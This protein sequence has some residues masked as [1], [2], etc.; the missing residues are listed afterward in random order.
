M[1]QTFTII[2]F[3]LL[4]SKAFGMQSLGQKAPS[5][6]SSSIFKLAEEMDHIYT[7]SIHNRIHTRKYLFPQYSI[8]SGESSELS[9]A[10]DEVVLFDRETPAPL[11]EAIKTE[12]E[13]VWDDKLL[14]ENI[15]Y[16]EETYSHLS[17]QN[18]SLA[19][20]DRNNEACVSIAWK[21]TLS[22]HLNF[23]GY[24]TISQDF[25]EFEI[26]EYS[27]DKKGGLSDMAINKEEAFLLGELAMATLRVIYAD[28]E[29]RLSLIES[30]NQAREPLGIPPVR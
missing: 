16:L 14:E 20:S 12:L 29:N 6:E 21:A 1:G 15:A 22:G 18:Y 13:K 3:L 30:L 11:F 8:S 5:E 25:H 10:E 27:D 24:H 19:I 9:W 2:I 4:G 28:T 23:C 17:I 7:P 26:R